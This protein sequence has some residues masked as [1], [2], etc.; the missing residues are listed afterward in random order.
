VVSATSSHAVP[1]AHVQRHGLLSW[2]WLIPVVAAGLVAYLAYTTYSHHGPVVTLTFETAEGLQANQT[3]V[4]HRAVP[5]GTVDDIGLSKDLRHVI[6]HVRMNSSAEP[7]L[8]D[9][10]RFWVVRPRLTARSFTGLETLVSGAFIEVD[11]GPLGGKKQLEFE[12]L[13]EPPGRQ[14]DE[15]GQV[16][17]LT[18]SRLGSLSVG[19]PV[20]NRDVEVG[21]LLSYDLASDP[22]KV[23]LRV[24]V[25]APFDRLVHDQTRFWNVSGVSVVMGPEGLH[26]ELESLQS[27]LNGGIAFETSPANEKDPPAKENAT[28]VLYRDKGGADNAAYRENLAYVTY[29]D[30]SIQ[31]LGRGAPVLLYGVQVGSVTDVRLAFDAETRRARARVAFCLQPERVVDPKEP[32]SAAVADG[33]RRAFGESSLSAQLESSS[34]LTGTKD[35][36]LTEA[37]G[38]PAGEL[39]REGDAIV[40]PGQGAGMEAITASLSDAATKVDRIP[41]EQIGQNMNSA[42]ERIQ[43][44]ATQIDVNATPA[45]QQLPPILDGVSKAVANANGALGA[46]GYGKNSEFEHGMKRVMDQVGDAARSLRALADYLDRHPEALLRGRAVSAGEP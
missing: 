18:A 43:H 4:K 12:G 39:P 36:A 8:T 46:G 2:V 23:H 37:P 30:S 13:A 31:G 3:Q 17:A 45:L 15:P 16:F 20:Y 26:A 27:V 32:G 40:V 21:E 6:V 42:L 35:V 44:L 28:F 22:E 25:R 19:A 29:F 38:R 7:M 24:F 11:P 1:E 9:H 33:L 10:A 41:F 5:L 14:S 34:L